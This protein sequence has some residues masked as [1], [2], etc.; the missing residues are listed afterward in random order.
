MKTKLVARD[1]WE[2]RVSVFTDVSDQTDYAALIDAQKNSTEPDR[3]EK[4][5]SPKFD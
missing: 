1:L 2:F 3:K 5:K 4:C